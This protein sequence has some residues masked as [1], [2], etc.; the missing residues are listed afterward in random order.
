M[1]RIKLLRLMEPIR[2]EKVKLIQEKMRI[3]LMTNFHP[4]F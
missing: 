1:S 2:K 4:S 3:K